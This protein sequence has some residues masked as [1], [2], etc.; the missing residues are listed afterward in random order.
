MEL[1]IFATER[2]EATENETD[3]KRRTEDQKGQ[4]PLKK[5]FEFNKFPV[6]PGLKN[7]TE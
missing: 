1:R 4:S 3:L 7:E 2:K 5:F 6:F